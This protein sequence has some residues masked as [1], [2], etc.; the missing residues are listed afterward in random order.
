MKKL[1]NW[2]FMAVWPVVLL[3]ASC[4]NLIPSGSPPETALSV[5]VE[6]GYLRL[7]VS[8]NKTD[9]ADSYELWHGTS[10]TMEDA[11]QFSGDITDASA[12]ITGLVNGVQYYVRVR[13]KNAHGAGSWSETVPGTPADT[14]KAPQ[15][16]VVAEGDGSLTLSWDTLWD[17]ASYQAF[18]SAPNANADIFEK[19]K[20]AEEPEAGNITLNLD[21]YLYRYKVWVRAKYDDG[22]AGEY[23]ESGEGKLYKVINTEMYDMG[24]FLENPPPSA[25]QDSPDN[26]YK[27]VLT[28]FYAPTSELGKLS[29][30]TRGKYIDLDMGGLTNLWVTVLAPTPE[31]RDKIVSIVFPR[32]TESIPDRCCAYMSNLR[33]VELPEGLKRIGNYAFENCGNLAEFTGLPPG[34]TH[35]GEYAVPRLRYPGLTALL[36]PAELA[37]NAISVLYNEVIDLSQ[38]K[39]ISAESILSNYAKAVIINR[40]DPPTVTV[41]NPIAKHWNYAGAAFG[42][43]NVMDHYGWDYYPQPCEFHTPFSIGEEVFIYV[44]DDSLE[45]YQTAPGWK[46]FYNGP[47]ALLNR[48]RVIAGVG[49]AIYLGPEEPVTSSKYKPLSELPEEYQ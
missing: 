1:F 38:V 32:D 5:S 31:N 37:D 40:R 3:C 28:D 9:D 41:E 17:A 8:W 42:T 44:P 15:N 46:S 34:L 43:N 25:L 10:E 27:I 14:K 4:G 13:P 24:Y 20:C 26:P 39:S 6:A 47:A 2:V 49:M 29:D 30:Y 35:L 22:S 48:R 11:E 33:S 7:K 21:D 19:I 23:S 12:V 16:L 45:A 18:Y 36:P